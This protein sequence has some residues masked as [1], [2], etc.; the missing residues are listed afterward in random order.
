MLKSI[1]N[2]IRGLKCIYLFLLSVILSHATDNWKSLNH[3]TSRTKILDSQNTDEEIFCS[4]EIPTRKNFGPTNYLRKNLLEPQ[5][6]HMKKFWTHEIPIKTK[7]WT[8]E[9]H[10]RIFLES[11]NTHEKKCWT[12]EIP[13]GKN[14]G[15]QRHNG[16]MARDQ[17]NLAHLVI[18]DFIYA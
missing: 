1:W 7:F 9:I 18:S 14:I 2:R 8:H 11:Q 4:H 10:T 5:N 13:T 16:T 15:P 12:M 17:R 6:S 3:E